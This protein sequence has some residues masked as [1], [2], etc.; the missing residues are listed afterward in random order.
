M[1]RLMRARAPT[2]VLALTGA[3]ALTR[4]RARAL[5]RARARALTRGR[6]RALTRDRARALTRGRA[7]ALTRLTEPRALA[8]GGRTKAVDSVCASN[9]F[10]TLTLALTLALTLVLCA[11]VAWPS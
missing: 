10:L 8:R 11:R 3:R 5:T 9:A 6:A 7:G 4:G 2:A 1:G